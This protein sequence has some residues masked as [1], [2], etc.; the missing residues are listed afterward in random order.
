MAD[1]ALITG[2]QSIPDSLI[3]RWHARLPANDDER[4]RHITH[5]GRRREFIVARSLLQALSHC[6]TGEYGVV[7]YTETGKPQW[8][9]NTQ[10]R[11]ACTISHSHG[12]VLV[13]LNSNGGIGVDIET[14][15]DRHNQRLVSRYFDESAAKTYAAKSASEKIEFFYRYWCD[16]EALVKFDGTR[17]LLQLL[18]MPLEVEPEIQHQHLHTVDF[19]LS[20]IYRGSKANWLRA[21]VQDTNLTLSAWTPQL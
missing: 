14:R 19:T 4:L 18:G 9:T 12:A 16:R 17:P 20:A 15:R 6:V 5:P 8:L 13:G 11:L 7:S 3:A 2:M 1:I 21:S 10:Q